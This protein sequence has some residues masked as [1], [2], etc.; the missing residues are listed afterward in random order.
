MVAVS[1]T[2]AKIRSL[3]QQWSCLIFQGVQSNNVAACVKHFALN[4]NEDNR[5]T[6]NVHVGERAFA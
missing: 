2:W 5:Y 1:N 4:N 3:R 6:T